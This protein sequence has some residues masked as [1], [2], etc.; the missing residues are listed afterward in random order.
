MCETIFD[1]NSIRRLCRI[2]TTLNVPIQNLWPVN[3]TEMLL[4]AHARVR[5]HMHAHKHT[6]HTEYNSKIAICNVN[7]ANIVRFVDFVN[8]QCLINPNVLIH[9]T[10]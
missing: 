7:C 10:D 1:R 4:I 9:T 8:S 5:V 6:V 2:G 3:K